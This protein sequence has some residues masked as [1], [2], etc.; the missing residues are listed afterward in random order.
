MSHGSHSAQTPMATSAYCPLTA[1]H[2]VLPSHTT[3][4]PMPNDGVALCPSLPRHSVTT[5][6]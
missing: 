6:H 5:A 2:C 4:C 1:W 3:L